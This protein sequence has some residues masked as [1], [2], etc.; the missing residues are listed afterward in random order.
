MKDIKEMN[1]LVIIYLPTGKEAKYCTKDLGGDEYKV[2]KTI[3]AEPGYVN[4]GLIEDGKPVARTYC[5]P[6]Y[7]EMF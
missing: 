4:I 2:V 5:M 6:Y 7:F 1:R 3:E